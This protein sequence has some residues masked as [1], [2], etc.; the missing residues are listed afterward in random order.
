MALVLDER[1][2]LKWP[3]GFVGPEG[4]VCG[5]LI[6]LSDICSGDGDI[7]TTD[8]LY[9]IVG[10]AIGFRNAGRASYMLAAA[11]I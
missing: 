5:L 6:G 2:S 1:L 10:I 4:A 3:A 8:G 7:G 9:F 11:R